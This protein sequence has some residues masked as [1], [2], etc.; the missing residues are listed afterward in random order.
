M[1]EPNGYK[2]LERHVPSRF[3]QL[4]VKG[5]KYTAER[6]FRETVGE[7]ARTPEELAHDFELPLE[8]IQEAIQYCL[9]NEE[10][11]LRERAEQL[12]RLRE[13]DKQM[14]PLMPLD[15]QGEA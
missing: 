5:K 4:F 14:P 12:A 8:A 13:R 6:I 1:N 7:D 11:L 15:Y 9:E 3:Q 10:L 2:Y